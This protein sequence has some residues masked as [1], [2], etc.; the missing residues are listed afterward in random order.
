MTKEN[1]RQ[2]IKKL[3]F[4][5][6]VFSLGAFIA[7]SYFLTYL[8]TVTDNAFVVQNITQVSAKVGGELE[9]IFI[10]NGQKV[11]KGD[12]LF[13]IDDKTYRLIYEGARAQYEQSLIGLDVL[14]KQITASEYALKAVQANLKLLQYQYEQK[15]HENVSKAVPQIELKDLSFEIEAQQ[16]NVEVLAIKVETDKLMLDQATQ[17]ILTLKATMDQAEIALN[18]TIV[19]AGTDGIVQDMFLGLGTDILPKKP[20]FV[21]LNK[22]T[23]YVQANFNETDLAKVKEG[24][25]V[26][27]FPRTYLGKKIFHGVVESSSWAVDRQKDNPFNGMQF[28]LTEN[29]WLLLPQRMPVII[30]ITNPSKKYPLQSGMSAYVYIK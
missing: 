24:D 21:I 12:I 5:T 25:E 30:R 28:I 3:N 4:A 20:L 15:S 14:K 29:K 17:G 11:K 2:F 27:I 22:D 1:I 16:N 18:D 6:I 7:F 23:I 13:K 10:K 9:E 26:L 19:H 8:F